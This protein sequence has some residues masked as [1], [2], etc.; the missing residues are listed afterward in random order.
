M[1]AFQG[2][3]A[4]AKEAMAQE[5]EIWKAMNPLARLLQDLKPLGARVTGSYAHGAEE[6]GR[7]DLDIYVPEKRWEEAKAALKASGLCLG[8][9]AIGQLYCDHCTP[10]LEVS[11]RFKRQKAVLLDRV[12]VCDVEM[13]TW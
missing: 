12:T 13:K 4:Q 6:L 10:A 7:S 3:S 9:S 1:A 2:E 5:A 11:W 8:S